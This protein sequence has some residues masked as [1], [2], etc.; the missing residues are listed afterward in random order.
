MPV[1]GAEPW[2]SMTA[3]RPDGGGAAVS[4]ASLALAHWA[5]F[6]WMDG[7]QAM[8]KPQRGAE[9]ACPGRGSR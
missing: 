1:A 8:E 5:L 7:S 9:L 6:S 3:S 2:R 4:A